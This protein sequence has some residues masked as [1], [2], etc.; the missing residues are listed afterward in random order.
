MKARRTLQPLLAL[1]ALLAMSCGAHAQAF[2]TY[3]ASNG[4]DNPNCSRPAPCRLLPAALA[5]V[6]DGGEVWI[7]DSA[8]YNTAPVNVAKSVTIL[9]VPGALGSVIATNGSAIEVTTAGVKLVLRNLVIVPLPNAGA[10]NGVVVVNGAAQLTVEGCSISN[11]PGHGILVI[12]STRVNITES[13]IRDNGD[14]GVWLIRGVRGVVTRSTISGNASAGIWAIG[15]TGGILTTLDVAA[16]TLSG[17]NNGVAASAEV[18]G[19]IVRV[20]VRGSRLLNNAYAG[21]TGIAGTNAVMTLTASDNLVS[22]NVVGIEARFAGSK[23]F[24]TG[25]TLSG[26]GTALRNESS[27]FESAG[28]NASRNNTL[29]SSGT[30]TVVPTL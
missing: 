20:S 5:A 6:A 24:A 16:S 21:A 22:N 30:I 23:A 15:D 12:G 3:L 27:L 8:N 4:V 17:N 7:L 1:L 11:L 28:N 25:N 18:S 29:D 9:A 14:V 2:R 10:V 19:S 26:N 13:V